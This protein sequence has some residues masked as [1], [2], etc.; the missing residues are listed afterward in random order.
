MTRFDAQ[1]CS[2]T[3]LIFSRMAAGKFRQDGRRQRLG[4]H[5]LSSM[6]LARVVPLRSPR[7]EGAVRCWTVVHL[8]EAAARLRNTIAGQLA[9]GMRPCLLTPNGAL[10]A[11]SYLLRPPTD[12]L[13]SISLLRSWQA[14]RRWR[15]ELLELDPREEADIVHAHSFSTGMAAVRTRGG[16]V[17]DISDFIEARADEHQQW[18]GRSLRVAEQ[19]IIGRAAAVVVHRQRHRAEAL[20][21]GGDPAGVFVVPE[22][23]DEAQLEVRPD[24]EWLCALRLGAPDAVWFLAPHVSGAELRLV[25]EAFAQVTREVPQARLMLA[26]H[27][28]DEPTVLQQIAETGLANAAQTVPAADQARALASAHVV[29][30][31]A[32]LPTAT[33]ISAMAAGRA[34]L[35]ADVAAH[36]DATPDGRGAVWF[37]PGDAKDLATR[38]A[39]LARNPDF[40]RALGQHGRLFIE[41][42]RRPE[43]VARKLDEVYQYAHAKRRADGGPQQFMKLQPNLA[44]L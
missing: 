25:L 44:C 41:E 33:S 5:L 19:F 17:Y 24:H 11:E 14:V 31:A 30:V 22:A 13:R 37:R 7:L 12:P 10:S 9:V 43:V 4:K 36:R 16:I 2:M 6:S 34:L 28:D 26:P 15:K 42:T 21:R 29:L 23:V 32:S 8:C 18:L 39:F 38:A 27:A 3:R 35:A 20:A 1:P 40:R